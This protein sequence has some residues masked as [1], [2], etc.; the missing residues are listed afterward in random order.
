MHGDG[1]SLFEEFAPSGAHERDRGPAPRTLVRAATAEDAEAIGRISAEREGAKPESHIAAVRRSL[2]DE[3]LHDSSLV[4]VAELDGQIVGFGKVHYLGSK[5]A[6]DTDG[7][8]EGWY[9]TGVVVRPDLRRRGIGSR[10]T[11]ARMRW[12]AERSSRVYYFANARN[13]VSIALHDSCGFVEIARAA[14]FGDVTFVGGEG[15]LFKAELEGPRRRA[16]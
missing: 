13:R 15:I 4:L 9:L 11:S 8:P 16:P 10:L 6:S 12:V 3:S 7:L 1:G 2:E 14:R 5:G